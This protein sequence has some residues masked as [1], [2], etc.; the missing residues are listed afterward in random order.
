MRNGTGAAG[1]M[2]GFTENST[3]AMTIMETMAGPAVP[4][5]N[6]LVSM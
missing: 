4:E 3:A 2:T 6:L 1:T 5:D